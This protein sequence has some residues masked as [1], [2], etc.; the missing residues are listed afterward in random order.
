LLVEIG[1]GQAIEIA[2]LFETVGLR[3]ETPVK[4]LGGIDRVLRATH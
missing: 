4:D 1:E 3:V 2:G